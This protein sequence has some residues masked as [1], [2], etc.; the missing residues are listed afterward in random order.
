MIRIVND[1]AIEKR[2]IRA[3]SFEEFHQFFDERVQEL[4]VDYE[5][6]KCNTGSE[7][8]TGFEYYGYEIE[9]IKQRGI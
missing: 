2:V 4:E 1:I 8:I 5:I 3:E 7:R 9:Y 6:I